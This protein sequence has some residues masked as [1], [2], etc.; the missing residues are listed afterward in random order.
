MIRVTLEGSRHDRRL[1]FSYLAASPR[2]PDPSGHGSGLRA[3][4]PCSSTEPSCTARPA[5][6]GSDTPEV[7]TSP[8]ADGGHGDPVPAGGS[9]VDLV[10]AAAARGCTSLQLINLI[11]VRTGRPPIG[12]PDD[13][14]RALHLEL[15]ALK[16]PT[17]VALLGELEVAA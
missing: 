5:N 8:P 16:P 10:T 15:D 17:T 3:S 13:I 12:W 9:E 11:R 4:A 2:V 7:S 1:V 6:F 14:E